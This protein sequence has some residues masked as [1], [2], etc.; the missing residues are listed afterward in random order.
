MAHNFTP[1]TPLPVH[2]QGYISYSVYKQ[3]RLAVAST[4]SPYTT[5]RIPSSTPIQTWSI[6]FSMQ[7]ITPGRC[8]VQNW[9][10][11]DPGICITIVFRLD[12]RSDQKKRLSVELLQ[13]APRLGLEPRSKAPEA[14]RISSTLPGQPYYIISENR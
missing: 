9:F 11:K 1:H 5:S 3:L 12:D 7:G 2:E 14:P 13:R 10:V 4:S 8:H 6:H